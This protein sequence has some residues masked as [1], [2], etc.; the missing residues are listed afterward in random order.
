LTI[1]IPADAVQ[2]ETANLTAQYA[3][4]ARIPGFRP[5]R[6]PKDVVRQRYRQEIRSEVVQTLVPKFFREAVEGQKLSV[7]GDLRFEE[8]NYEHDDQPITVKV[9]FEVVPEFELKEFKGLEVEQESSEV[10]DEDVEK[11]LSRMQENA[12]TF[13]V[14][15]DR[16]AEDSDYLEVSYEGRDVHNPDADP[17]EVRQGMVHLG[18]G[19][20]LP[21]FSEHLLGATGGQTREFD[22]TYPEDY[23]R[24]S[25]RGKTIHYKVEVLSIKRKVLPPLDDELAK[26]TSEC[27]TLEELR[28]KI[29]R[30]MGGRRKD[31]AETGVRRKLVEKLV[32]AHDFPAPQKM[33]D[34]QIEGKLRG[35]ITQMVHQGID[36]RETELDWKKIRKELR[37]DAEKAVKGSLILEKIADAEGIEVNDDEVD[38]TIKEMAAEMKEPPATLKTRLTREGRMARISFTRRNQKALDFV[39]Q[40]AK[41]VPKSE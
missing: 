13:E 39:Y 32:E 33:V 19:S 5:G 38:E 23:P 20:T 12:A 31:E 1:E 37:P 4:R 11:V 3:K 26:A 17:I 18:G 30:E 8:L 29:R 28:A 22:V 10:S 15:A 7:V 16:A 14:V 25:T 9:A 2:K 24:P 6:A 27:A 40:N 21:A 36:P 35:A 34:E 41:I